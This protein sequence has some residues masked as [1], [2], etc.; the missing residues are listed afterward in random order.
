[1]SRMNVVLCLL[2]FVVV[3][4]SAS[5]QSYTCIATVGTDGGKAIL[6]TTTVTGSVSRRRAL[7]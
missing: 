7:A 5:A 3:A 1:M 6:G 2:L 4:G